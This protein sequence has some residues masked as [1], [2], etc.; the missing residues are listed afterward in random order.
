MMRLIA[1]LGFPTSGTIQ[2]FDKKSGSFTG[3]IGTLIE[4]PSLNGN[5]TAKDNLHFYRLLAGIRG[6][7]TDDEL[8]RMVGLD[9]IK[10]R[11]VKDYSLG[12]RQRLGIAIA[13][14]G[15]PDFVMLD[16]PVNGLDPIGVV[17]IR[18]LIRQL[19]EK[20]GMTILIS[21]HNLP[22]LYQTATDY[23]IIDQGTIKEETTLEKLE[24]EKHESLEEYFLSAIGEKQLT[25]GNK[26]EK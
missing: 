22:E 12:M 15:N 10:K 17:E 13:L 19:C 18:N 21:S 11:R 26:S 1:G 6:G 3:R 16:E 20:E 9:N 5:M 14:L 2:L 4:S 25:G 23:I 24:S 8:L 7:K